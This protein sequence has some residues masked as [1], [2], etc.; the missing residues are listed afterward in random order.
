[1]EIKSRTILL[2]KLCEILRKLAE[3]NEM[4]FYFSRGMP[5]GFDL[6]QHGFSIW[7]RVVGKQKMCCMSS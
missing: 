5:Q 6:L 7:C 3:K 2:R 4:T 1:M